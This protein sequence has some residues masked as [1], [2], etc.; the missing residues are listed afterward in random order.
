MPGRDQFSA[1]YGQARERFRAL[2]ARAGAH[3]EAHPIDAPGPHGEQLTIDLAWLGPRD[4]ARVVVVSSALHGVEGFLG[5]AVQL[6]LLERLPELPDGVALVFLHAL[7]PYG[8]AHLRRVNEDNVDLN[9]NLLR[10]GER[11]EGAPEGYDGFDGLLNP[12]APPGRF[13][14]LSF[15]LRALPRILASGLPK[16]KGIVAGGQYRFPKGVFYGGSGP[17]KT[18][19]ILDEQVPRWFGSARRLIQLDLHSGLGKPATYKLLCDHPVNHPRTALLTRQFGPEVQPWD[20]GDGV[21]YAI[22]GGL[23]TWMIARLPSCDVDVL[24]TEFGTVP[25][26]KVIT[27]LHCEN[28][29]HHHGAP[30]APTTIAAKIRIQET[31][32][33]SDPTWRDRVVQRGRAVVE[34]ALAAV[35]A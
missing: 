8:F 26:L 10:D 16:L 9:R 1:N 22:R 32:A 29:A 3:Q 7:N 21:A 6:D 13:T 15:P 4:A 5:S 17:T 27:A 2:A 14:H 31:F 23:G 12:P 24:C 33:P 25:P 28:R 30:D 18:M 19:K 11:W 20:A 34:Q 35:L